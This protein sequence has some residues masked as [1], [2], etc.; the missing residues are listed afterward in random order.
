MNKQQ[1]ETE[2]EKAQKKISGLE[3]RIQAKEQIEPLVAYLK[4]SAING[5]CLDNYFK[6]IFYSCC[7]N[8]NITSVKLTKLELNVLAAILFK[9]SSNAKQIQIFTQDLQNLHPDKKGLFEIRFRINSEN[10]SNSNIEYINRQY[11]KN[12]PVNTLT[13]IEKQTLE[14]Q[15][16]IMI[17]E[18]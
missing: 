5:W 17:V 11:G 9:Y 3:Y 15:N 10:M 7:D 1:L 14:E 18:R 13:E 8:T 2:L 6:D 4:T 16:N 12:I